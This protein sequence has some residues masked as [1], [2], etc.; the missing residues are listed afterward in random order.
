M[1]NARGLQA[2]NMLYIIKVSSEA[3][4]TKVWKQLTN[5]VLTVVTHCHGNA[6]SQGCVSPSGFWRQHNLENGSVHRLFLCV[7]RELHGTIVRI[8][9]LSSLIKC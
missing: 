8:S 7:Q 4:Q 2:Y 3:N 9:V 1:E 5:R 6:C